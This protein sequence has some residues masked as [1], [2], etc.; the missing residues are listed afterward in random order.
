MSGGSE[1]GGK[2]GIRRRRRIRST[3][4][5]KKGRD[6]GLETKRRREG[7][8][9][10]RGARRRGE[11]LSLSGIRTS[12]KVADMCSINQSVFLYKLIL[13]KFIVEK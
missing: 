6:L 10:I 2:G 8:L 4:K 3:K 5:I 9:L 1:R 13:C 11:I 12:I 7:T